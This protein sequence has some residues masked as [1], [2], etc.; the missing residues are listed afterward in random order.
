MAE[1]YEAGRICAFTADGP[2]GPRRVAK[3][4]AVQLAALAGAGWIGC[5]HPEPQRAWRLGSWDRF[6]IPWPFSTVRFGWPAH[7]GPDELAAV[8]AALVEA[9]V[10]ARIHP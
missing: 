3:P 7:V 2:K 1:A 5:F 10:L 9:T 4:G 6:A 8:Q